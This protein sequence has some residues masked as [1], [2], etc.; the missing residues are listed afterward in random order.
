MAANL[1][2]PRRVKVPVK[3]K[4]SVSSFHGNL[5][6]QYI[7]SCYC[8]PWCCP[9]SYNIS[10]IKA[11]YD[12][13]WSFILAVFSAHSLHSMLPVLIFVYFIERQRG[14]IRRFAPQ[15]FVKKSAI[16]GKNTKNVSTEKISVSDLHS[17]YCSSCSLD[18]KLI[19]TI[20]IP[21]FL[22]MFL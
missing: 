17:V 1:S 5:K 21:G 6:S 8:I 10:Y 15:N 20:A 14:E 18:A 16:S 7:P 11:L 2:R 13:V 12:A 9:L 3:G 22:P 4:T 19:W